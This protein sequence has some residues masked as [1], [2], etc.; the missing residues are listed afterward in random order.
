MEKS[1]SYYDY[2]AIYRMS[3]TKGWQEIKNKILDKD[4]DFFNRLLKKRSPDKYD[5]E[6]KCIKGKFITDPHDTGHARG[7]LELIDKIDRTI[8]NAVK[9]AE[10]KQLEED[11]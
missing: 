5:K 4:E 8:N 3:Q 1:K 10:N 7:V 2:A 9:K 6:G 11:S